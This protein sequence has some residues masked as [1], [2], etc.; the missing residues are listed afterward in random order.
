MKYCKEHDLFHVKMPEEE[1][2]SLMYQ[3][4]SKELRLP[5]N[6]FADNEC[7]LVPIQGCA[8][9]PNLA[10]PYTDNVYLHV[11]SGFTLYIKFFNGDIRPLLSYRGEDC[12]EVLVKAL[13]REGKRILNMPEKDMLPLTHDEQE[14]HKNVRICHICKN[15]FNYS[16]EGKNIAEFFLFTFLFHERL[17]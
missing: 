13:K 16:F 5:F 10:Q 17:L 7:I 9:D 8:R 3:D 14:A 12:M 11:P 4:G 2:K 15:L 6:F 1:E